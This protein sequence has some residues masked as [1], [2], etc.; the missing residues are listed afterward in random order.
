[1]WIAYYEQFPIVDTYIIWYMELY[2][3]QNLLN[4]DGQPACGIC[5]LNMIPK[6][7]C[8]KERCNLL[9]S[10]LQICC[11]PLPMACL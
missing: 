9:I 1:M 3:V 4:L 8:V 5:G 7:F 11:V 10:C 2:H 6:S